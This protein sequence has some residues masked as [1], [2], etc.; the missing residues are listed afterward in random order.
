MCALLY[1]RTKLFLKNTSII[2]TKH[3]LMLNKKI[4]TDDSHPDF[5]AQV[6]ELEKTFHE[7]PG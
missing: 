4:Y 2:Y 6:Q 7:T 1:G 3:A 5:L